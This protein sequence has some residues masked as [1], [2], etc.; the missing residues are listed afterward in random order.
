[1]EIRS[2]RFRVRFTALVAHGGNDSRS[3]R[4]EEQVSAISI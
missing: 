4:V 3:D 1:L 2:K